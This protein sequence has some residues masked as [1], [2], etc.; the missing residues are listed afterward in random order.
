MKNNGL[1]I[2]GLIKQIRTD[3]SRLIW[4]LYQ[5]VHMVTN[6]HWMIEFEEVPREIMSVLLSIFGQ[7]PTEGYLIQT[8]SFGSEVV[9]ADAI[10]NKGWDFN[11]AKQA[12]VTKY[13]HDYGESRYL[14]VFKADDE[15]Y[16]VNET[17]LQ[18]V[19]KNFGFENV[20]SKGTLQ[21]LFFSNINYTVLPVRMHESYDLLTLK[22]LTNK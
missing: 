2:K 10:K 12:T 14:R 11:N 1:N 22:E 7:F 19:D 13:I 21:P 5:G 20:M 4:S 17:Y 3:K 18:A 8:F 9:K 15:F 6:R 16:F